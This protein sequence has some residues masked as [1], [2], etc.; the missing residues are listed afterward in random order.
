MA[1]TLL[2]DTVAWDLCLDAH[3]NIAVATEPYAVAQDVASAVRTFQG[4]VYYST[5]LGVPY[6]L[7]ILGKFPPLAL[8]KAKFNAAALTVPGVATAVTYVTSWTNR[9]IKGQVQITTTTG[10]KLATGF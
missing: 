8:V 5:T 10:A 6:W 7:Q 1:S 3:G 2:L 4:E 9:Q